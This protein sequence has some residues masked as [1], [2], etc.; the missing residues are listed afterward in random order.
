MAKRSYDA[1]AGEH[2]IETRRGSRVF[3]VFY[4]DARALKPLNAGKPPGHHAR[5]KVGWYWLPQLGMFE[6]L[7]G[8]FTSSRAAYTAARAR[9]VAHKET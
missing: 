4:M 5:M 7:H 3:R 9:C 8:A 1:F 6:D 2:T